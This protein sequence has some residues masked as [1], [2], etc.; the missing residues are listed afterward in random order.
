MTKEEYEQFKYDQSRRRTAVMALLLI[1]VTMIALVCYLIFF[2]EPVAL[3]E[4]EGK[5]TEGE[6]V[7]TERVVSPVIDEDQLFFSNVRHLQEMESQRK[8]KEQ[9]EER[10]RELEQDLMELQAFID[11]LNSFFGGL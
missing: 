9:R 5:P 6:M 1:V 4:E 3:D 8:E 11:T 10:I 7:T 2:T